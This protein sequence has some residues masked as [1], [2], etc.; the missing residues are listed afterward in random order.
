MSST[1]NG[2]HSQNSPSIAYETDLGSFVL[3][4]VEDFL[5]SK[6]GHDLHRKVDLIF[7]SPPFPLNRKK[8]Y[9]NLKGQEYVD[10]LAGLAKPLRALLKPKGSIV[11]ELGNA[12]EQGN[13]GRF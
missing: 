13:A 7:T 1:A 6:P 2:H 3:G 8:K 10:W 9:G 4:R 11:V 12:W 5:A